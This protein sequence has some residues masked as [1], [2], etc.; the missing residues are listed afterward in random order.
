MLYYP[1][2]KISLAPQAEEVLLDFLMA[3][4][5]DA[6]EIDDYKAMSAIRNIVKICR[7]DLSQITETNRSMIVISAAFSA[8]NSLTTAQHEQLHEIVP[9]YSKS[10]K[11]LL[12]RVMDCTVPFII[13]TYPPVVDC[14]HTRWLYFL[15]GFF[16]SLLVLAR[17]VYGIA[18]LES[19]ISISELQTIY[20]DYTIALSDYDQQ[21]NPSG[22]D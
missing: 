20:E 19:N 9:E 12:E 2:T 15:V 21:T 22:E 13:S 5:F 7:F 14:N 18:P 17:S 1:S 10:V 4:A 3:A 8:Y 11:F 16:K 6:V